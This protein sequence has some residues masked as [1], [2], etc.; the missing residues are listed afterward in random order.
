MVRGAASEARGLRA[1][2]VEVLPAM[3]CPKLD[4]KASIRAAGIGAD[5]DLLHLLAMQRDGA[6]SGLLQNPELPEL[7]NECRDPRPRRADDL[8]QLFVR[9]PLFESEVRRLE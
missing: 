2:Q 3:R 5:Q 8:R 4:K 9:D 6:V 7:L 1:G